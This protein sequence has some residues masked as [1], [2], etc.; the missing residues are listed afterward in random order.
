MDNSRSNY[1]KKIKESNLKI[2]PRAIEAM[3]ASLVTSDNVALLELVKNAYD[4][5]AYNVNVRICY[6]N[7]A[8]VITDDGLGM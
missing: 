1:M 4:A 7:Q 3:G 5:Y 8:I 2:H 6:G